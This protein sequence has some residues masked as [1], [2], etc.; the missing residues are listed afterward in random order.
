MNIGSGHTP[1]TAGSRPEHAVVVDRDVYVPARDG[2]RVAVDIYRPET[3]GRFPALLAMSPYGKDV[4][5]F[6]TPPQPFGGPVF[7]ASL[8]SGDP[9]YYASRG[10]VYVIGDMRGTGHSEGACEG[11]CSK[12]EGQD[13]ADVV[14]WLAEQPWC[15][16]NVAGAG[17]CYFSTVQLQIAAERPPHPRTICPWEIPLVDL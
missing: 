8:E 6:D 17:I 3:S 2:V 13:G 15:D 12:H 16:G 14:E 7:E 10:Y 9:Y 4:Q 5:T 11:V 1:A